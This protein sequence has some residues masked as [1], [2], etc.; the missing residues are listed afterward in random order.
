M[1]V[2]L[3]EVVDS[4]T[5]ILSIF[6]LMIEEHGFLEL[7]DIVEEMIEGFIFLLGDSLS[8]LSLEKDGGYGFL[9]IQMVNSAS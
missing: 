1:Q 9:Q 8:I 6:S 4:N 2:K 5:L 7:L 3:L